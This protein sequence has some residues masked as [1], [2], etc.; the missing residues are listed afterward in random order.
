MQDAQNSTRAL[1]DDSGAITQSYNYSAYGDLLGGTAANTNYLYT[2]QRLD[3]ITGD[4]YLR[5]RQYDPGTGRF[6][7]R[8]T[9]PLDYQN[10]VE[11]NRYVYAAANP[12]TW[13]DPS[14]Y[15][16]Q[17]AVLNRGSASA[18]I[19]SGRAIGRLVGDL[20]VQT[21]VTI[22]KTTM[23]EAFYDTIDSLLPRFLMS[24]EGDE[25]VAIDLDLSKVRNFRQHIALGVSPQLGLMWSRMWIP[26][27]RQGIWLTLSPTWKD[28]GVTTLDATISVGFGKAFVQAIFNPR[29]E[30]IHFNLEGIDGDYV[31]FM[32]NASNDGVYLPKGLRTSNFRVTAWELYTIKSYPHI[33]AKTSFYLNGS[34]SSVESLDAKARIC[35]PPLL[36]SGT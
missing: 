3:A 11:L 8:D 2:G 1:T 36:P 16:A 25:S 18:T 26:L 30:R 35:T 22:I 17:Q 5:A 32:T 15:F 34:V 31:D 23:Y 27:A 10:P 14:G 20:L 21:V 29:V 4:Y 24:A 13:S 12:A 33:C 28:W 6:L 19:A 9:W 7:S